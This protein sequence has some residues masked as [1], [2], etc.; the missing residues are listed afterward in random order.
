[1]IVSLKLLH[2]VK[3]IIVTR[4]FKDD[5]LAIQAEDFSHHTDANSFT[6]FLGLNLNTIHK[7]VLVMVHLIIFRN[8]DLFSIT[9]LLVIIEVL[10]LFY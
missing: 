4:D 3:V 9:I 5:I 6:P 10:N 7:Q 8:F 1:M 2:L